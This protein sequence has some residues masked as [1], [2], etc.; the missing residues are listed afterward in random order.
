MGALLLVLAFALGMVGGAALFYAGQRSILRDRPA[1]P[2]RPGWLGFGEREPF[3][4]LARVADLEPAQR[5]EVE[6]ILRETREEMR[7][8]AER[9]RDRMRQVLTPEQMDKLDALRPRGRRPR[10]DRSRPPAPER[11]AT[12]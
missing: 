11:P 2:R 4:R 12:P 7:A 1:D 10:G 3:E 6:R 5:R 9:S 8:V